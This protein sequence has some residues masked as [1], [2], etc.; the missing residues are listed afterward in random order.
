MSLVFSVICERKKKVL[1]RYSVCPEGTCLNYTESNILGLFAVLV[2]AVYCV[3][4]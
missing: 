1:F 3:L 2:F 4:L